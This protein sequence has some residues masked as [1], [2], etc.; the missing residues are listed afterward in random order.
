MGD[1][2]GM[3]RNKRQF[4]YAL[5]EGDELIYDEYGDFTGDTQPIYGPTQSATANVS[6]AQG[7]AQSEIFGIVSDYDRVIGPLP[8]SCPINEYSQIWLYDTPGNPA[9]YRV[10][11][12][13][14]SLNHIMLL[15]TK[16]ETKTE[17]KG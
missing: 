6:P 13:A 15:V 9:E 16:I 1:M 10:K 17:A 2:R 7:A 3:E 5:Y 14:I 8:L 4:S 11:R 12:R